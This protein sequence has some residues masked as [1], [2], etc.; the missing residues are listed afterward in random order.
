MQG[1]IIRNIRRHLAKS[2]RDNSP[3]MLK[4]EVK[5]TRALKAFL[6]GFFPFLTLCLN[7][8]LKLSTTEK[9]C[10]KENGILP[11]KRVEYATIAYV[12]I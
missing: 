2:D 4:N 5:R 9:K 1:R 7:L 8:L 11:Q 6:V 12:T 10:K 3:E